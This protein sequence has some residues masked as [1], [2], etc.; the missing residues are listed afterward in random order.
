MHNFSPKRG[1]RDTNFAPNLEFWQSKKQLFLK[2]PASGF[3]KE[4]SG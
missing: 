3:P 2:N 1:F 4:N